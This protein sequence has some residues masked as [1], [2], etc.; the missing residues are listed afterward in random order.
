MPERR[1]HCRN[2]DPNRRLAVSCRSASVSGRSEAHSSCYRPKPKFS[3][4]DLEATFRDWHHSAAKLKH[5]P[6][7]RLPAVFDVLLY[8]SVFA[9]CLAVAAFFFFWF[10]VAAFTCFCAACLCVAFGDLSPMTRRLRSMATGVNPEAG[11]FLLRPSSHVGSL[12]F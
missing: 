3:K 12:G 2:V 8:F 11:H 6:H 5:E 9:T 10:A 4:G 7:D 1:V